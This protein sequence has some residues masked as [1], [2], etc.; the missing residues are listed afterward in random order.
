MKLVNFLIQKIMC[1]IISPENHKKKKNHFH[2]TI[3]I[4]NF[5]KLL[6]IQ[7]KKEINHT[8]KNSYQKMHNY[9]ILNKNNFSSLELKVVCRLI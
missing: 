7:I 6:I 5:F 9:G 3:R 8:L 4:F 1:F 2:K